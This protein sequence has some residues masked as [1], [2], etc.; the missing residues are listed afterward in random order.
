V[1]FCFF[2]VVSSF[3]LFR[4]FV[5]VCCSMGF[6]PEIKIYIQTYTHSV[7]RLNVANTVISKDVKYTLVSCV[8]EYSTN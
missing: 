6:M 5:C 1:L 4:E 3:V 7:K 8:T 2:Q